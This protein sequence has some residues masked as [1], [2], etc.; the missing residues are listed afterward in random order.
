[1]SIPARVAND[2]IES[3]NELLK[4][5]SSDYSGALDFLLKTMDTAFQNFKL[6]FQ[7]FKS[8]IVYVFG[9]PGGGKST[10]LNF[11]DGKKLK[12]V[13]DDKGNPALEL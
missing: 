6:D 11:L 2:Y 4:Q 10:L 7:N 8:G 5:S 12:V 9:V 13:L 3:L 1:M